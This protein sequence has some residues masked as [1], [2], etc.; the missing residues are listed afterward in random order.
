MFPSDQNTV[1]YYCEDN[2]KLKTSSDVSE[3]KG[4]KTVKLNQ[5]VEHLLDIFDIYDSDK[6]LYVFLPQSAFISES[7]EQ[8]LF[9]PSSNV[10]VFIHP[11]NQREFVFKSHLEF[12][13]LPKN[14]S[15]IVENGVKEL[16]SE[17]YN[18]RHEIR[19]GVD[20]FVGNIEKGSGLEL[21]TIVSNSILDD[22][23]LN[24]NRT[25]YVTGVDSDNWLD[26]QGGITG[27]YNSDMTS[28]ILPESWKSRIGSDGYNTYTYTLENKNDLSY[29]NNHPE[30]KYLFI[31]LRN[32]S[33][34]ESIY[35]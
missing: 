26:E 35:G 2:W 22:T 4:W 20:L 11:N 30:F 24:Q 16:Y 25:V 21:S 12:L 29:L 27:Y 28:Y 19:G 15:I 34:S 32:I 6:P 1:I 31:G 23:D 14:A 33:G 13:N 5:S 17:L 8:L 9:S 10:H 7:E 18:H 3:S